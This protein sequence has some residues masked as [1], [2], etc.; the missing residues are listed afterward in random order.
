MKEDNIDFDFEGMEEGFLSEDNFKDQMLQDLD[1]GSDIAREWKPRFPVDMEN[2]VELTDV[3]KERALRVYQAIEA[4]MDAYPEE[5]TAPLICITQDW[6][7]RV[8]FGGWNCDSDYRDVA[9]CV[10]CRDEEGWFLSLEYVGQCIP[11][12]EKKLKENAERCMEMYGEVPDHHEH[13]IKRVLD[14]EMELLSILSDEEMKEYGFQNVLIAMDTF[15]GSIYPIPVD[16]DHDDYG[17][18]I[19]YVPA[20]TLLKGDGA[21]DVDKV[22]ELV[23]DFLNP[24]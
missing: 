15:E 11:F 4:H 7:V 24:I 6:R 19:N 12:I 2:K 18:I 20:D 16:A 17:G 1:E 23:R 14:A 9:L 3:Q 8:D 21:I 5:A 10:M 22:K 13:D